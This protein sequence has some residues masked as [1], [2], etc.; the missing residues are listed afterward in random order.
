MPQAA[1]RACCR[2]N[3]SKRR[4]LTCALLALL[5]PEGGAG[6]AA[7]RR[8][9]LQRVKRRQVVLPRRHLFGKV[10]LPVGLA[11]GLAADLRFARVRHQAGSKASALS[12]QQVPG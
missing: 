12:C 1:V 4:Q 2:H 11:L 5:L 6:G 7:A 10:Q 8:L 9:L 3:A